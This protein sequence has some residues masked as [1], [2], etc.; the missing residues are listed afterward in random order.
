MQIVRENS[1][2]AIVKIIESDCA[3]GIFVI[4]IKRV[5]RVTGAFATQRT[6]PENPFADS[7]SGF[8]AMKKFFG[9]PTWRLIGP[10]QPGIFARNRRR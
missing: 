7:E 6:T 10:R 2:S 1:T 5:V 8:L 3:A 9:N 4:L